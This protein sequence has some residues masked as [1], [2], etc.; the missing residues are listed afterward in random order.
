MYVRRTF[1]PKIA[2]SSKFYIYLSITQAKQI[3]NLL[4]HNNNNFYPVLSHRRVQEES[5]ELSVHGLVARYGPQSVA[6]AP[7]G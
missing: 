3:I 4:L 1:C 7:W 2:I 6:N 5:D